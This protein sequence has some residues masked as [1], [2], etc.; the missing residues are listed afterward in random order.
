[1]NRSYQDAL[2]YYGI[3]GAHPGS[4]GLTKQLLQ[5]EAIGPKTRLLDAGCGTGQTSAYISKNYPC[6]VYAIDSHPEMVKKAYSR[7]EAEGLPVRLRQ[8]SIEHMPFKSEKFDMILAESSTA[9][10]TV[11]K[12]LSEYHRVLKKEGVLL[13]IDMAARGLSARAREEVRRFYGVHEVLTP[14]EW[15]AYFKEAG[16]RGISVLKTST[17]NEEL[18]SYDPGR[19]PA[20][21]GAQGSMPSPVYDGIM[22]KHQQISMVYGNQ[23]GYCVFRVTK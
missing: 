5:N 4:L 15:T 19:L 10:T 11:P 7:F 21:L 13:T 8:S 14:E 2:A 23:L 17:I 6:R 22:K 20:N 16:F 1:M 12:A 9:F 3:E 18:A